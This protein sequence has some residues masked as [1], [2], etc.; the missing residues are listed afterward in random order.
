MITDAAR[1]LR[2]T[3]ACRRRAG[4]SG[5]HTKGRLVQAAAVSAASF[6]HGR[7]SPTSRIANCVVW[8]PTARPHGAGI[9]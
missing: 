7:Y 8:T 2:F 4:Q 3:A 5:D 6:Q 9:D 1:D